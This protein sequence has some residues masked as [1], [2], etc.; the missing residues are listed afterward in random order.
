MNSNGETALFYAESSSNKEIVKMIQEKEETTI[1]KKQD[2]MTLKDI[3]LEDYSKVISV[4]KQDVVPRHRRL[5]LI[6]HKSCVSGRISNLK[7][8]KH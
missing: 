8:K 2:L 1:K 5:L 6:S 4:M 3:K 7:R